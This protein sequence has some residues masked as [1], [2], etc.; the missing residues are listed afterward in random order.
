MK[1]KPQFNLK[2]RSV[3]L[4]AGS[5]YG[6]IYSNS[7]AITNMSNNSSLTKSSVSTLNNPWNNNVNG[8]TA[9]SL[10]SRSM[11][12]LDNNNTTNSTNSTIK[13]S[14]SNGHN[15]NNNNIQTVINSGS[16]SPT[17]RSRSIS[18]D[19][20]GIGSASLSQLSGSPNIEYAYPRKRLYASI[21][22]RKFICIKGYKPIQAGELE[23]RK[24]D[25][26]EILSVGEQ[27]FWE[28]RSN[29]CEGWF[30]SDCVEEIQL[31]KDYNDSLVVKRKTLLDLIT[32]N[33]FNTPRTVVLQRGKKG[34][35]FVLRGAKVTDQKFE[36][37]TEIPAL[38]FL[39]NVDKG[40]NADKAGLKALDF[41]LEV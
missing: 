37:T 18:S 23:L 35:G 15:A 16:S 27:G 25:I 34:Y 12:K 38:Q 29:S 3:Y 26:V 19:D 32:Q 28:G 5:N 4:E 31:P 14:N 40:S 22:D 11:P 30:P 2:R 6:T 39:E 1:D 36:P 33:D 24:G 9:A 21:P 8:F 20:H 17:S 41:V 10:R 13:T 7:T